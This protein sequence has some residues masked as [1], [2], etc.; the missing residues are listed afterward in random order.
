MRTRQKQLPP[1]LLTSAMCHESLNPSTA[2]LALN[3]NVANSYIPPKKN[4]KK[5][6]S[7]IQ[8]VLQVLLYWLHKATSH[9]SQEP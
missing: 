8:G 2:T 4:L 1:Q 3:Y 7:S 9:T 5:S 6:D